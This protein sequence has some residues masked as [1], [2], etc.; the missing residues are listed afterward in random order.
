MPTRANAAVIDPLPLTPP[1]P[2][3]ELP[4]ALQAALAA[5]VPAETLTK[6]LSQHSEASN[7]KDMRIIA[8]TPNSVSIFYLQPVREY[9]YHPLKQTVTIRIAPNLPAYSGNADEWVKEVADRLSQFAS[10]E[11]TPV[12][13][14][15]PPKHWG[16]WMGVAIFMGFTLLIV[17]HLLSV[18]LVAQWVFTT[19]KRFNIAVAVHCGVLVKR[20]RDV[21]ELGELLR[22][23]WKGGR[24]PRLQW[25]MSGWIEGWRAVARFRREAARVNLEIAAREG[26]KRD[27][28][29]KR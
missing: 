19:E 3:D 21:R 29:K 26:E 10:V 9:W 5:A 14:Y 1:K 6:L 8:T 13:A 28:K 24:A 22:K 16:D 2:E 11:E 12:R 4:S 18:P 27:S 23:H 7:P 17:A 15:L 20:S 25:V